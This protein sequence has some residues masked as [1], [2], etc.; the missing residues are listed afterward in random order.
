M[1]VKIYVQI[2]LFLRAQTLAK[3]YGKSLFYLDYSY[4]SENLS[5]RELSAGFLQNKIWQKHAYEKRK[6]SKRPIFTPPKPLPPLF[7]LYDEKRKIQI[8]SSNVRMEIKYIFRLEFNQKKIS[9]I[10]VI[11]HLYI[12]EHPEEISEVLKFY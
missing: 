2:F 12:F 1:F 5:Q 7:G 11:A 10:I 4:G 3:K 9:S 8:H 6:K